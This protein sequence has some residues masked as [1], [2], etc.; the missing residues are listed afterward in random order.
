MLYGRGAGGDPT[1]TSVVGDLIELARNR[2]AGAPPSVIHHVPRPSEE[3]RRI[4]PIEELSSQYYILMDVVDRHGVLA[5]I[6][7][8]FALHEVSIKQVLQ[9]GHGDDARLVMIT[10]RASERALRECVAALERIEPVES[11]RSVIRVAGAES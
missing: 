11:V 2:A 7:T 1:A 3:S 10:H 8:V 4:R 9:E 5:S 6:A